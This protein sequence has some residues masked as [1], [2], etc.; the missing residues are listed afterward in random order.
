[1]PRIQRSAAVPL[2]WRWP[3]GA[4]L[5]DLLRLPLSLW[6]DAFDIVTNLLGYLPLGALL[7]LAA[8]RAGH[9]ALA[10]LARAALAAA[11]LSFAM[12]VTQQLLPTRVPSALDWMLNGAGAVLGGLVALAADAL[13]WPHAWAQAHDR[14]FDHR[15]GAGALL[16]LLLWPVALLFPVPVPLGL[17][18]TGARLRQSL[19]EGLEGVPWAVPLA[20]ALRTDAAPIAALAAPTEALIVG[21]GLLAPVLLAFA[22]SRPGVRRVL[23]ALAAPAAAA[24]AT[25]LSTALNFGPSHAWAWRTPTVLV[26]LGAATSVALLLAWVGPR[27]AAGLALVVL[28]ALLVLVQQAPAD[29]YFAQS[30]QAWERGRFIRFHGLAQWVGWLWPYAAL[31]WLLARMREAD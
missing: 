16:L 6:T 8:R 31:L 29:P 5:P 23:L 10:S 21:L 15:R 25:T 3:P 17:G 28:G 4:A 18:Q 11:C 12:E 13:G 20:E 30:L 24:L 22:A 7:T 19:L 1:M 27:L 2:G 14:W 26:A 9:G